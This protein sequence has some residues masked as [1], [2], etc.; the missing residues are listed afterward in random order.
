M[1]Q[2]TNSLV[3]SVTLL[4]CQTEACVTQG[5][6]RDRACAKELYQSRAVMVR[7]F[8]TIVNISRS[9]SELFNAYLR[10]NF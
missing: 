1:L 5:D 4:L 6:R 3:S 9:V 2:L 10:L 8:P 7:Q